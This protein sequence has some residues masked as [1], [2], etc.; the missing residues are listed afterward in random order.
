V[1]KLRSVNSIVIPAARSGGDSSNSRAVMAIDRTSSGIRSSF[2][3][4]GCILIVAVMKFT[5]ACVIIFDS[6]FYIVFI[7]L[8][9]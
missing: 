6:G 8:N 9:S 4:F 7:K 2:M 5:A 1:S 3:L